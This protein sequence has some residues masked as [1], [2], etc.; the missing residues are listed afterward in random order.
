MDPRAT[1]IAI[2]ARVMEPAIFL[3]F[4]RAYSKRRFFLR[5]FRHGISSLSAAACERLSCSGSANRLALGK[6]RR[7]SWLVH[8]RVAHS[9]ARGVSP[10]SRRIRSPCL[11]SA[12]DTRPIAQNWLNARCRKMPGFFVRIPAFRRRRLACDPPEGGTSV[13]SSGFSRLG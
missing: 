2:L 3:S 10:I 12:C 8:G 1:R 6:S 9:R 7:L 5:T 11:C 4:I 13:R